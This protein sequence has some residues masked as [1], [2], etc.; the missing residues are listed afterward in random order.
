MIKILTFFIKHLLNCVLITVII[1]R[2]IYF[3]RTVTLFRSVI[4]SNRRLILNLLVL[5]PSC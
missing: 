2:V 3:S 1:S 4:Q 5:V